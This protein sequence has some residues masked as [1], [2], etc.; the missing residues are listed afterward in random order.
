MS[1]LYIHVCSYLSSKGRLTEQRGQIKRC[2]WSLMPS[3]TFL[4]RW[5]THEHKQT[6]VHTKTLNYNKKHYQ[7]SEHYLG[8]L[9][10]STQYTKVLLITHP[11]PPPLKH[12]C[13]HDG[14][15][16]PWRPISRAGR[17][18][19]RAGVEAAGGGCEQRPPHTTWSIRGDQSV[20]R[21]HSTGGP[22][23]YS[24]VPSAYE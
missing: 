14:T 2:Q 12:L 22:H 18:R 24:S 21:V 23:H 17:E 10:A 5:S 20:A 6:R 16:S 7:V 3:A 19:E 9:P 4:P 11:H 13:H 1:T 8:T 15:G